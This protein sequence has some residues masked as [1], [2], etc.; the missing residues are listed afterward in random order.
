MIYHVLYLFTYPLST[1]AMM[2]MSA[3]SHS[4]LA[5]RCLYSSLHT[6]I[7][8]CSSHFEDLTV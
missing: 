6:G 1:H 3:P 7:D 2:Q 4:N 5:V 8:C